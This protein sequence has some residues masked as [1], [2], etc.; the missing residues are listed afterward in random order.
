[1]PLFK[2][3][4]HLLQSNLSFVPSNSEQVR[5]LYCSCSCFWPC[6]HK[7]SSRSLEQGPRPAKVSKYFF[8]IAVP[9]LTET[10]TSLWPT[11]VLWLVP[12]CAPRQT[13]A[14]HQQSPLFVCLSGSLRPSRWHLLKL[15]L[16]SCSAFHRLDLDFLDPSLDTGRLESPGLGN[17]SLGEYAVYGSKGTQ[18]V[19]HNPRRGAPGWIPRPG[20]QNGLRYRQ[21]FV[22]AV[23]RNSKGSA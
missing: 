6:S 1:M 21:L 18:C 22:A 20:H 11:A 5:A 9:S 14:V 19:L 8:G 10:P 7:R 12:P 13:D 23:K 3:S 4:R 16:L 17:Q 2:I 15:L